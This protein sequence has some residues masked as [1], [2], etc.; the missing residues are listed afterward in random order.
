M[1]VILLYCILLCSSELHSCDLARDVLSAVSAQMQRSVALCV[2]DALLSLSSQVRSL[3]E[4]HN[5]FNASWQRGYRELEA[6]VGTGSMNNARRL[7]D[8]SSVLTATAAAVDKSSRANKLPSEPAQPLSS[9]VAAKPETELAQRH[10]QSETPTQ[11]E[12][13]DGW[14]EDG[15]SSLEVK[16]PNQFACFRHSIAGAAAQRASVCGRCATLP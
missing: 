12:R 7:L 14:F 2:T 11:T 8:D 13:L 10:A 16:S 1:C 15:Q 3:A 6:A 9:N 5:W 4:A